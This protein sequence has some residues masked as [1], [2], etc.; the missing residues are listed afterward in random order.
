MSETLDLNQN[1]SGQ[2]PAFLTVI[3]I[4]SFIGIGLSVIAYVGAFALMGVAEA[5]IGGLDQALQDAGGTVTSTGPST[6]I[7]WTY[8]IVGFITAIMQL[9]GVVQ[10][11][12]LKKKGFM[13]YTIAAIVGIIVG[14]IYGG[15]SIGVIFPIAFV[16]M[17]Y[18]NLK[19]MN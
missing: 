10:M 1:N 17:Y 2:R 14:I 15:F 4:L 13:L 12:K 7:I 19:A 16:V 8:I 3:C 9:I 11:W 18:L 6:A 5:A